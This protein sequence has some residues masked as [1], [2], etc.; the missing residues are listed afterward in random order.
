[1]KKFSWSKF[2]NISMAVIGVLVLGCVLYLSC[3]YKPKDSSVKAQEL[4]SGV[5]FKVGVM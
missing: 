3:F 2:L 5:P 4:V 1:M